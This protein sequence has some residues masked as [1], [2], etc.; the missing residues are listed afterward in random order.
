MSTTLAGPTVSSYEEGAEI[1]PVFWF[2]ILLLLGLITFGA[3]QHLFAQAAAG[4][5][6]NNCCL[7]NADPIPSQARTTGTINPARDGTR[8]PCRRAT[9]RVRSEMAT[10]P[11]WTSDVRVWNGDKDVLAD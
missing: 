6:P 2:S 8:M 3:T 11:L 4:A 1:H 10:S 9:R 7:G 5:E